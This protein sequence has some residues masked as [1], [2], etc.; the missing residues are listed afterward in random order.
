[1]RWFSWLIPILIF[2]I[3]LAQNVKK[4]SFSISG[5]VE[6]YYSF[7]FKD[8]EENPYLF[9]FQKENVPGINLALVSLFYERHKYKFH[10]SLQAGDYPEL[11]LASEHPL[12]RHVFE[13]W[14]SR[15][16]SSRINIDAGIFPSHVGFESAIG[17]NNFTLTRSLDAETTPYYETGIRA[18]YT[19]TSRLKFNLL[20][21]NGWQRIRDNNS[22]PAIGTQLVYEATKFLVQ[23]STFLGR[24]IPEGEMN[25][26]RFYNDFYTQIKILPTLSFITSFDFGM[27]EG[28]T[29]LNYWYNPTL[30]FQWKTFSKFYVAG[31][32]EYYHD[33]DEVL[34]ITPSGEG[35]LTWSY[36]LN[37]DFLPFENLMIRTEGRYFD[38]KKNIFLT[39][40]GLTSNKFALTSSLAYSF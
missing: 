27:E 30:L 2:N 1:M 20:L 31:R 18:G 9:N 40:K 37:F 13:A 26:T 39:K 38:S 3:G 16:I 5:Y 14:I 7:S 19:I 34:V 22:S 4:D 10:L 24:E 33:P 25:R 12:F 32:A 29:N 8:R 36:S 23:Y 15:Q 11:N 28:L 35:F 21:L 17:K 6:P